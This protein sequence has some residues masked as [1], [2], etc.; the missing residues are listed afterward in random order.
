MSATA[1][2]PR[3]RCS[4][5][6]RFVPSG[7]KINYSQIQ[8]KA[9]FCEGQRPAAAGI[10]SERRRALVPGS[11][12]CQPNLVVQASTVQSCVMLAHARRREHEPA[13]ISRCAAA[14]A[15]C[16]RCD[17]GANGGGTRDAPKPKTQPQSEQTTE[18]GARKACKSS[19]ARDTRTE[20]GAG[21]R[22]DGGAT[23]SHSFRS[24]QRRAVVS[25]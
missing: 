9:L 12:P 3:N 21:V 17:V 18:N 5:R 16:C 6:S 24:I 22:T 15:F 23:S 8:M 13:K 20:I 11:I 1:R 4:V 25:S 10:S 19:S 14:Y 7:R 2:T